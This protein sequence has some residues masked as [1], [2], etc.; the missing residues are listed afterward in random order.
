MDVAT[1]LGYE[2]NLTT[3]P[4]QRAN[5]TA[6]MNQVRALVQKKCLDVVQS[7]KL[8]AA[9]A[10]EKVSN[11]EIECKRLEHRV[12]ELEGESL[13][14]GPPRLIEALREKEK[15]LRAETMACRELEGLLADALKREETA[16]TAGPVDD[17]S[18]VPAVVS[19][20]ATRR[21]RSP[22]ELELRERLYTMAW[23][24]GYLQ[25]KSSSQLA[26]LQARHDKLVREK[27]S[28]IRER[29]RLRELLH[30]ATHGPPQS[31]SGHHPQ[32]KNHPTDE[33]FD[34]LDVNG[35]GLQ[36]PHEWGKAR[37]GSGQ[38]GEPGSHRRR[39]GTASELASTSRLIV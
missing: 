31:G 3:M 27:D 39:P 20:Q 29:L 14:R 4:H 15:E 7:A 16:T 30:R 24:L 8:Y 19:K 22:S 25:H 33:L 32:H 11:F 37:E 21:P 35:D 34:R 5:P 23:R 1:K 12:V 10:E 2:P 38:W 18:G 28:Q 36:D 13:S 9:A 17:G 26:A 6:A